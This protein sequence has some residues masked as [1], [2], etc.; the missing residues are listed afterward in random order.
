MTDIRPALQQPPHAPATP[1]LLASLVHFGL[2]RQLTRTH[3][4][5]MRPSPLDW[6]DVV[7][8]S[9]FCFSP[10]SRWLAFACQLREESS[11]YLRLYRWERGVWQRC[12]MIADVV[13]PVRFCR[14]TTV[15]PDTLLTGHGSTVLAWKKTQDSTTWHSTLVCHIAQPYTLKQLFS[16]TNG[17]QIVIAENTRRERAVLR[18]L[19]LRH[20]PDDKGW[21]TARIQTYNATPSLGMAAIWTA[22]PQSCQ[23]ALAFTT[24]AENHENLT[25]EVHIWRK[26]RAGS[27]PG[28]WEAHKC[29]L[30]RHYSKPVQM[31]YS[32]DGHYLLGALSSGQA[33]LWALDAQCRLQEQLI[34]DWPYQQ[35]GAL[36]ALTSFRSDGQQ[37]A[38]SRSALQVQ[39]FYCNPD[40]HWQ[41]GP[42]LEAPAVPHAPGDTAQIAL[43]LSASGRTLVRQTAWCLD[44]W[45]Q[46]PA[47]GWQHFVQHRREEG[48]EFLPCYWLLQLGELVCATIED[49]E[50]TL[51]VYG[52]DSRGQ[53]V[54]K[55]C[56]PVTKPISGASPDGLSL[57]LGDIRYAPNVLQLTPSSQEDRCSLL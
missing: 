6:P 2:N 7:S 28:P 45:H 29:I 20:T 43:Q 42:L 9:L 26:G 31:L 37:L 30:P 57:V 18:V 48:H 17:D 54:T 19:L 49:P 41:Q 4:L 10:C 1:G 35:R 13:E 50:L 21:E 55:A 25:T 3:R 14:F 12:R 33:C 15:P 46:A 16:M 36:K 56:M 11:H 52:P 5:R 44:I 32:P 47:A 51:R 40:G 22:H 27:H 8:T 53:L 24:W 39:L 38:L 23:L 34:T